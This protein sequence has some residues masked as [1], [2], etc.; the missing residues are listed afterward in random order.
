MSEK[1][2]VQV[3][4]EL[5]DL[6]P[7]YLERLL[8]NIETIRELVDSKDFDQVKVLGHNLKGSGGGY[9]F[10]RVSEL[11]AEM[12]I[13]ARDSDLEKILDKCDEIVYFVNNLEIEYVK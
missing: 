8:S 7:G 6:V 5:M 9:G 3:D 4:E 2:L 10:D 12:E 1:I 13:A 11:G